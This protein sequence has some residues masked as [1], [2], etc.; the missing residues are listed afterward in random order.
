MVAT[1]TR[2][3]GHLSSVL[4][5]NIPLKRKVILPLAAVAGA[6][7]LAVTAGL[8]GS[9]ASAASDGVRLTADDSGGAALVVT[10]LEPGDSVT[11]TVT[12]S[13]TTGAEGRLSFTEQGP[14]ATFA[15]GELRLDISR[16]GEQVF[17]GQFGAMGD[18]AQDMGFLQAGESATFSFTVSL[19]DDVDFVPPGTQSAEASYTW[20]TVSQ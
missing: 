2:R 8:L 4:L 19:P 12:I 5:V 3:E 7:I 20:L 15:D 16:D 10:A 18:F 6:G 17:A 14:A 9:D 11:R 13:N 1:C